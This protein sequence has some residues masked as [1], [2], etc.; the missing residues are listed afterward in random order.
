MKKWTFSKY[1]FI[2][3][4]I[5]ILLQIAD[6]YFGKNFFDILFIVFVFIFGIS[7]GS[8]LELE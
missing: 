3:L 4:F 7:I 1:I 5:I 6:L 8:N 2:I